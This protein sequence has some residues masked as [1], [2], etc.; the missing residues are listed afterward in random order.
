LSQYDV[1]YWENVICNMVYNEHNPNLS[2][3]SLETNCGNIPLFMY[4]V[5]TFKDTGIG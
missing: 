5:G 1:P 2:E 4:R 3:F